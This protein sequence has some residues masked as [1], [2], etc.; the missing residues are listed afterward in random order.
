LIV[1]Q[2]PD[3]DRLTKEESKYWKRYEK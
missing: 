1:Y 3:D 2:L